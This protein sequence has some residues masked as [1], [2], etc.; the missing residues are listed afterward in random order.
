[1]FRYIATLAF[2]FSAVALG[3]SAD[4]SKVN[5]SIVVEAGQ[6]VGDVSTVN[7]SITVGR[8]SQVE[9]V[10]TV[11]GSVRL[12]ELST[13][14][15]AE[16]VNGSI[17]VGGEAQIRDGA[18]T[19]NGE[20]TLGKGARVGGKLENVNGKLTLEGATVDGGISTV[21]GD[22]YVAAGSR[23]EGG[24][25]VE[26]NQ[27]WNW[28]KQPKNPR[29]TIES[30]AVVNGT[31]QF[32]R[33]VPRRDGLAAVAFR[34]PFARPGLGGSH[35]LAGQAPVGA[36]PASRRGRTGDCVPARADAGRRAG[37]RAPAGRRDEQRRRGHERR[38]LLAGGGR[39]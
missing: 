25:H 31:L 26:K 20:L 37:D 18:S 7:G 21:H 11:N 28:G 34:C 3:A 8:G 36:G 24:I 12:E 33:P 27:G 13:A 1:M 39:P 19:V 30:G 4:I 10:A 15:S 38:H 5:G 2:A 35:A 17:V 29:V 6:Q 32:E 16:T 22:V 14:G 9:D 23:I